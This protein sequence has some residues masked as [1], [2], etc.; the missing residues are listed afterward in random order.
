MVPLLIT[1]R[2]KTWGVGIWNPLY[3]KTPLISLRGFQVNR[4]QTSDIPKYRTFLE[5]EKAPQLIGEEKI[6]DFIKKNLF[7]GFTM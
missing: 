1:K 4:F 5:L 7:L 3:L 6:H 2:Y